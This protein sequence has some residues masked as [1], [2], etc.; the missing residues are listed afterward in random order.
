MKAMILA[1]GLGT[2]LRPYTNTLPKPLLPVGGTPLIVWNLLL[3]RQYGI[4][5]VMINLHYLGHMIQQELGDGALW[6]MQLSYSQ[7]PVIL[8]TGGGL[9]EAEAFF[10]GEDVLVLNGDTLTELDIGEVQRVHSLS[11]ALVT[12]VLRDDP[13][14]EQWG[15]VETTN[16]NHVLRINGQGQCDG[17]HP[18]EI[19]KRM[20]AGVHILNPRVLSHCPLGRYS[21]IIDAYVTELERGSMIMGHVHAGYWSD[22]GTPERYA[23]AQQDVDAG[24]LTLASRAVR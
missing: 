1:A 9:R 14:V 2:R 21:S 20:F 3:L 15:V 13:H 22:I 12:M 10:Q 23:Q 4:H 7:E 5:E 24:R 16:D 17:R 8:G 11:Q 6:G 19:R 18:S